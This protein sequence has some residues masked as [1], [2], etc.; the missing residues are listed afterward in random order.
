MVAL[1]FVVKKFVEVLLVD[2]E[3]VTIRVLMVVVANVEVDNTV[4]V[5]DV[6]ALPLPSTRKLRFSFQ[7]EPFQYIVEVVA[8]PSAIRP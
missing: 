5:P 7:V 6:V 2:D 3:L 1:K 4:K 8:V